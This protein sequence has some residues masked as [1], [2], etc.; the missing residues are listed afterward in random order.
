M[1]GAGMRYGWGERLRL[2]TCLHNFT[3]IFILMWCVIKRHILSG[4]LHFPKQILGV[5]GGGYEHFIN[6]YKKHLKQLEKFL[7]LRPQKY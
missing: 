4:G 6:N 7:T 2:P 1:I 3:S 5:E